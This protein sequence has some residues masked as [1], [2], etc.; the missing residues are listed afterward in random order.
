MNKQK[1]TLIKGDGI[2]PEISEAVQLIFLA[3]GV[4]IEWEEAEAGFWNS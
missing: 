2:G 4:P 3:A 1:V